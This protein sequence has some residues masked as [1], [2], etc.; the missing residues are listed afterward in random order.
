MQLHALRATRVCRLGAEMGPLWGEAM[1][2]LGG[3]LRAGGDGCS[4][5]R[6]GRGP[7]RRLREVVVAFAVTG[8]VCASAAPAAVQTS[9]RVSAI[10][11]DARPCAFFL[12]D[13]VSQADPSV[14]GPWFAL[15]KS[16]P[17]F[18]QLHA[19]ILSARLTGS[20]ITVNTDGTSSC[21]WATVT[22]ISIPY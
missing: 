21:G 4:R 2:K 10:L 5:P 13:G 20:T 22:G 11:M 18:D 17:N 7:A 15:P 8:L 12:L 9:K 6:Q 1:D 16:N 3:R 19:Y 14:T